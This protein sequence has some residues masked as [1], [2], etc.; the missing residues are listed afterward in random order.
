[1]NTTSQIYSLY[2]YLDWQSMTKRARRAKRKNFVIKLLCIAFLMFSGSGCQHIIIYN[3]MRFFFHSFRVIHLSLALVCTPL[4]SIRK[5]NATAIRRYAKT[6]CTHHGVSRFPIHSDFFPSIVVVALALD[7]RVNGI[8][9][10]H[11]CHLVFRQDDARWRGLIVQSTFFLR[12]V[13]VISI[14]KYI[15]VPS[16]ESGFEKRKRRLDWHWSHCA[17]ENI[18]QAVYGLH[19]C[20]RWS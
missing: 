6:T 14:Y 16:E 15:V 17:S 12:G 19:G 5:W 2:F 11:S 3:A 7:S 18:F 10:A 20:N 8:I 1:M 13:C 4:C 9:D